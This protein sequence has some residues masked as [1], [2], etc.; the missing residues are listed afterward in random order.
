[1]TPAVRK[2]PQAVPARGGSVLSYPTG[3]PTDRY[4][5]AGEN[6]PLDLLPFL[7]CRPA[8]SHRYGDRREH[9]ARR[10]Q[11]PPEAPIFQDAALERDEPQWVVDL[12]VVA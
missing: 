4:E 10:E 12:R 5:N 7:S 2:P 6:E 3:R 8:I 11:S 1:M 9:H